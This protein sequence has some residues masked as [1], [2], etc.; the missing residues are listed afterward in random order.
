MALW[1][2]NAVDVVVTTMTSTLRRT[3]S[4]ASLRE[5]SAPLF[6]SKPLLKRD[7]LPLDPS[8]F[9]DFLAKCFQENRAPE[10]VL[11]SRKPIRKIF[12]YLLRM[13]EREK[14]VTQRIIAANFW[15]IRP[16]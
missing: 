2:T 1:A 11:F 6:F 16:A 7:I 14:S 10:A 3:S 4:A 12:S 15:F 9:V 8:K 5:Y 13:S